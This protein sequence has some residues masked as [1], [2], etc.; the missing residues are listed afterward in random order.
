MPCNGSLCHRHRPD[1][2]ARTTP[3]VTS[4]ANLNSFILDAEICTLFL[5]ELQNNTFDSH[6]LIITAL[7]QAPL[8]YYSFL[9]RI[10]FSVLCCLNKLWGGIIGLLGFCPLSLGRLTM[11]KFQNP[12]LY[13]CCRLLICFQFAFIK[14]LLYIF[15]DQISSFSKLSL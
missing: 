4:T 14:L 8:L 1:T 15:S 11:A 5:I 10:G 7:I 6:I 3:Y 13:C 2:H 9:Q 12:A